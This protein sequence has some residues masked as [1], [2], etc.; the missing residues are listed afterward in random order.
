[1]KIKYNNIFSSVKSLVG[2][3]PQGTMLGGFSYVVAISDNCDYSCEGNDFSSC[4]ES[5]CYS[6]RKCED[7]FAYYD[8]LNILELVILSA[9]LQQYDVYSHV[10]SDIPDM[11]S[12]STTKTLTC[13]EI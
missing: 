13:R 4:E 2:G 9:N 5:E 12:L 11:P 3:C 10:P 8:D 7:G 6:G 1:M